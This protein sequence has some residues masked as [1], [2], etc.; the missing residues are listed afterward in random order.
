MERKKKVK[1]TRK[2]KEIK[3]FEKGN[4][5]FFFNLRKKRLVR[6]IDKMDP[7]S[8]MFCFVWKHQNRKIMAER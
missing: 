3:Q 6:I 5:L 7:K 4:N 1:E 8:G 2:P